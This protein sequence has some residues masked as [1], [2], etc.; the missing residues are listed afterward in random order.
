MSI[1]VEEKLKK[2]PIVKQ[3]V[4]VAQNIKLPWLH[5]LS[6][7]DLLEIYV[8]GII[9]GAISYR[10]AAIAFSFFMAL[11]PFALFILNLI[12]FI[13]LEGFQ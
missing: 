9:E 2:I 11:L 3:L 13:P 7:Y 10:A 8:V 6:F 12:P 1:E 4:I 5:G